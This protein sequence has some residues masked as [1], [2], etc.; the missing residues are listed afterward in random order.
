MPAVET[1]SWRS[2]MALQCSVNPQQY[3]RPCNGNRAAIGAPHVLGDHTE[4][5]GEETEPTK[6]FCD[7]DAG[8]AAEALMDTPAFFIED[9]FSIYCAYMYIDLLD[10]ARSELIFRCMRWP[11]ATATTQRS[12]IRIFY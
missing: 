3:R 4:L 10:T 12:R 1:L 5:D 11:Q 6:L 9:R 2:Q 7:G 8:P